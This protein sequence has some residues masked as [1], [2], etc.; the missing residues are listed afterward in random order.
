MKWLCRSSGVGVVLVLALA[1]AATATPAAT[2]DAFTVRVNSTLEIAAPG[3]LANDGTGQGTV[4]AL[5]GEPSHG[6]LLLF[7]DGSFIYT[8]DGGY[9]GTDVFTYRAADGGGRSDPVAVLITVEPWPY[10]RLV[11]NEIEINPSGTDAGREWVELYNATDQAIDLAGWRISYTYR[12]IGTFPLAEAS[13]P[14]PPGGFFVFTYPGIC[15]VNATLARVQLFD[16][17]GT[18][19]DETPVIRDEADDEKS[20]QRFP[21]GG[22][23]A[24]PDLWVFREA[25]RGKPLV[26]K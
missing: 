11:I 6:R 3:V 15:L 9:V 7:L 13:R 19:I 8:P 21:N 22:D 18:V 4:A 25:T 17:A 2:A 5:E 12:T 14:L 20:W 1:G 24:T 10:P 16:P 26:L 23:P